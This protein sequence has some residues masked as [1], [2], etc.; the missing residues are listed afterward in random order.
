M[1][2]ILQNHQEKACLRDTLRLFFSR[3]ETYEE[4]FQGPLYAVS[5]AYKGL[6]LA[7]CSALSRPLSL[8]VLRGREE[9]P[10][11]TVTTSLIPQAAL[12][13]PGGAMAILPEPREGQTKSLWQVSQTV[14][15]ADVRRELKR[16]AYFALSELTGISW[17][18]GSLTGVRPSQVAAQLI[19][20]GLEPPL[21]AQT[22]QEHFALDPLKAT[23]LVQ[24][25]L[26]E[27]AILAPLPSEDYLVYLGVPFCPG[28]CA[29]CSFIAQ[30]ASRFADQLGDYARAL[31]REIQLVGQELAGQGQVAA[32]YMGGGTPTSLS[33]ADLDLVLSSARRYLPLRPDVELTVEAGRADTL[34]WDKLQVMQDQGIGRLCINPQT[35]QDRTLKRIGRRHTVAQV[36]NAFDLARQAGF[37][38]INMDLIL[39]LP[40]EDSQDFADNLSQVLGLA[41][42]SLT[43]HSLAFKRSAYLFDQ[44]QNLSQGDHK[45]LDPAPGDK[46]DPDPAQ[47]PAQ[48]LQAQLLLPAPAWLNALNQAEEDLREAGYEAYY[49]YRQKQVISGLE[50]TGYAQAGQACAYNVG[51]M[52]DQRQVIGLGAGAASKR[53]KDGHLDRL[54]NSKDLGEYM[55]KIETIARK[56]AQFFLG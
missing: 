45:D 9:A 3:L 14:P 23:K 18:W 31:A 32:L 43:I 54:Y 42:A 8:N 6:D 39:G 35:M 29:Y 34:D 26:A 25:T 27:Q 13:D 56:K 20:S 51:M 11:V 46:L 21:L 55:A 47:P 28:R 2:F 10:P 24:V 30:D 50:N 41:P 19:D 40:G 5:P 4:G 44:F 16:Q 17:P 48:D 38:D 7:V 15:S 52:S 49:L 33:A 37:D 12:G 53:L 22:L 1:R 36:Y